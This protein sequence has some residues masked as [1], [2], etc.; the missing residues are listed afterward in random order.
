MTMSRTPSLAL[1]CVL[2]STIAS[3]Q[4][5]AG[6]VVGTVR[7]V[8]GAPVFPAFVSIYDVN[9]QFVTAPSTGLDGVYRATLAAG[10]YFALAD[11]GRAY[12]SQMYSGM[13]CSQSCR[14]KD[15]T[16]IRVAAGATVSGIDFVLQPSG[17]I[18]GRITGA[19]GDPVPGIGLQ[20][21]D[22]T[23]SQ[24]INASS[25]TDGRYTL[26]QLSPGAWTVKPFPPSTFVAPPPVTV[27]V[28][29]GATT[30]SVDFQLTA[31]PPSTG[32]IGGRITSAGQPAGLA[33]V[34][35]F[36]AAGN[37]VR[38][39]TADSSGNYLLGTLPPGQY[40]VRADYLGLAQ[41]FPSVPCD[42]CVPQA[43]TPVTVASGARTTGID[44][45]MPAPGS[46]AGTITASSGT[47]SN[48]SV[49]VWD[50]EIRVGITQPGSNGTYT[51]SNLAP[52]AYHVKAASSGFLPKWYG[53]VLVASGGRGAPATVTSGSTTSGIDIQVDPEGTISGTLNIDLN[54]L[55]GALFV[56]ALNADGTVAG[57]AGFSQFGP[58]PSTYTIH[59]LASGTY[60]VV[61]G[62]AQGRF[63]QGPTFGGQYALEVYKNVDCDAEPCRLTSATPVVVTAGADTSG[64]D[65]TLDVGAVIQGRVVVEGNQ[66]VQAS[67]R[68]QPLTASPSVFTRDGR[69]AGNLDQSFEANGGNP[70]DVYKI[71]ALH[72]GTYF[73]EVE[74]PPLG[75]APQIY[76]GLNCVSCL[77]G[78]GTPVTIAGSETKT[79]IDFRL[80][81]AGS[82]SG[83]VTDEATGAPLSGIVLSL[84]ADSGRLLTT[85]FSDTTG[86]YLFERINAG[87]YFVATS[88]QIGYADEVYDNV[89]CGTCDPQRG[90]AI[91]VQGGAAVSGINFTLAKGML[92]TGQVRDA[93]GSS[94]GT[95][96]VSIFDASGAA[97]AHVRTNVTG[98]YV[99]SVPAGTTYARLEPRP[100]LAAQL[101]NNM[102]CP[103][104]A[105]MPTAGTPIA[106]AAGQ[107]AH[108]IDFATPICAPVTLS[109]AVLPAGNIGASYSGTVTA[110]PGG[111]YSFSLQSGTLPP[112]LSFSPSGSIGGTPTARGSYSFTV[113]AGDAS[114]C[115]GS[116]TTRL[117]VIGCT[118][119][120]PLTI[121]G[122][123]IFDI[124][125]SGGTIDEPLDATC[126]SA[127]TF[128]VP[129]LQN[130]ADRGPG[131]LEIVVAPN[132]GGP[133]TGS[134]TIGNRTVTVNQGAPASAP[135]F[136]SFDVPVNAA[137]VTGS[138]AVGGWVL[139]DLRATGVAIYRSPGPGETA[140][141][142]FVGNATLVPGARPDVEQAFPEY[143]Y[144]NRAGW[145][146]LLL[147]NMLPSQG[148]GVFTLT[149]I[150]Q[151]IEG[152]QTVLGSR[153]IIAN[154]A[155]A[156]LPFGAIDTPG[157]GETISGGTYIN[158]GWALTPNPKTIPKDGS[159]I[160]VF[161]D[162]A[163]LGTVNY[164]NFRSDIASVFPGLNNTNGAVG[165]R[166]INTLLLADGIHT[167]SW[168]VTDDGGAAQGIG[169]RFFTVSNG[170]SF[171][172][173]DV[174]RVF[175]PAAGALVAGSNHLRQ[176]YGGQEDPVYHIRVRELERIEI[177]LATDDEPA[178]CR[179]VFRGVERVGAAERPLPV[180][181]SLDREG[182]KFVWHPGPGFIGTYRLS[183][184]VGQCD[185]SVRRVDVDVTIRKRQTND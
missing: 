45:D 52:G 54:T 168:G 159:T 178:S 105:C 143:P 107:I 68:I 185:G 60:Y 140:P 61:A 112:G 103:N 131:T 38:Q 111:P 152:N 2:L 81:P 132:A 142:I 125:G 97:V 27:N 166:M 165:Y 70:N 160:T 102:P 36:N 76:K 169:S 3:A 120:I 145:G 161:I 77:P 59:G 155:T 115:G 14:L 22:A 32:S 9:V 57:Q 139:D 174:G 171:F 119:S 5:P 124:P 163:P 141:L 167:I 58:V 30:A 46:I 157:Q 173:A 136:G 53:N 114:G 69:R 147:T 116:L 78:E 181:S 55:F 25:G 72:P 41:L 149:A 16:A 104:G 83:T 150:A 47:L 20:A 126:P 179:S 73:V 75:F 156:T 123:T 19:A 180:G 56:K 8:N 11:A 13:S 63:A 113:G 172:A 144:A 49:E 62:S 33:E 67:G 122:A 106:G 128:N 135:P 118:P 10:T 35:A 148:N 79:G 28:A 94:G 7:D 95:A 184:D 130:G 177:P 85:V 39:A 117:D 183:F 154:N 96:T 29:S 89:P 48:V 87:R 50:G 137:I 98:A 100:T 64:I 99:V 138:I 42:F 43:G 6:V 17:A 146:Y 129:W 109:P 65:L 80:M 101:Y 40:F 82:I 84:Y 44:F 92:I 182:G 164:N 21:N 86:V 34:A 74:T 90:R 93:A 127:I 176:G 110:T 153:T 26:S 66:L 51:V 162:G 91:D 31:A 18:S 158:F 175:I 71:M 24:F 151:D 88:N 23:R 4:S 1:A 108:G 12:A 37:V 121:A 134:V 15:A 133:R 170:S